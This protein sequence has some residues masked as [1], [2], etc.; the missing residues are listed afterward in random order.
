MK[1]YEILDEILAHVWSYVEEAVHGRENAMTTPVFAT[2]GPGAR[3]V[4]LRAFDSSQRSLSFHTDVRS[5]KV[6]Q[7]GDNPR[8]RWVAWDADLSQQFQ[9]CGSTTVHTADAFADEMWA[10]QPEENLGFYYKSLRPGEPIDSPVSCIDRD[11]VSEEEARE[12]F[13]AVR[14]V[15]DEITW[16]HLHPEIEY[17]ARFAWDGEAFRGEW[18]VP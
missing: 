9:F 8:A 16:L 10:S 14:T 6:K 2:D 15:V 13:A 4:A 7:I 3:T 12:N 18:I 1:R 5:E 11:V 17:R